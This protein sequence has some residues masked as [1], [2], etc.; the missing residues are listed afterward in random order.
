MLAAISTARAFTRRASRYILGGSCSAFSLA[1]RASLISRSPTALS[2]LNLTCFMIHLRHEIRLYSKLF[3]SVDVRHGTA[4]SDMAGYLQGN[5]LHFFSQPRFGTRSYAQVCHIVA[6]MSAVRA[7]GRLV[8]DVFSFDRLH[9]ELTPHHGAGLVA[10][11]PLLHDP[12]AMVVSVIHRVDLLRRAVR[13]WI[14][15]AV[16]FSC[17]LCHSRRL[18]VNDLD[19]EAAAGRTPAEIELDEAVLVVGHER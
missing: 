6:T 18:A 16:L 2:G 17:H 1:I 13:A 15:L 11:L 5:G 7:H 3:G 12:G 4:K 14:S 9:A 19:A 8:V 10:H